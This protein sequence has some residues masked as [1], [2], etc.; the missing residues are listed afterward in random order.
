LEVGAPPRPPP[1]RR[2]EKRSEVNGSRKRSPAPGAPHTR[3]EKVLAKDR[4][5]E[6]AAK[7][8]EH[9]VRKSLRGAEHY[10]RRE[11]GEGAAV[12]F[13]WF[14]DFW[15]PNEP[16]SRGLV[17]LEGA[18]PLVEPVN[19]VAWFT[20]HYEEVPKKPWG[21]LTREQ[22]AYYLR[23]MG[24]LALDTR[25]LDMSNSVETCGGAA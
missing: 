10:V 11:R 4:L 24:T 16:K 18:R 21:E 2:E 3:T 1:T 23:L 5:E 22:Q 13:G 17:E 25:T 7:W 14:N 12:E 6:L 9:D 15:M 8:P 19:F 20:A